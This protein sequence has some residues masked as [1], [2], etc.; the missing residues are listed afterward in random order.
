MMKFAIK[1]IIIF[2]GCLLFDNAD[3]LGQSDRKLVDSYSAVITEDD[4][5]QWIYTA[6]KYKKKRKEYT[7][8]Y[9]VSLMNNVELDYYLKEGYGKNCELRKTPPV[10]VVNLGW[11]IYVRCTV[12]LC[13]TAD[14]CLFTS[15]GEYLEGAWR[16]SL[17]ELTRKSNPLILEYANW[18]GILRLI[19]VS[20][21]KI[22]INKEEDC[23]SPSIFKEFTYNNEGF[24]MGYDG[25]KYTI[26][27]S[28]GHLIVEK[29][30]SPSIIKTKYDNR[31]M[32][33]C[34]I[35][36]GNYEWKKTVFDNAGRKIIPNCEEVTEIEG[37]KG[38]SL[39][40]VRI[41]EY[42]S[43][44]YGIYDLSGNIIIPCEYKEITSIKDNIGDNLFI[45]KKGKYSSDTYYGIYNSL[46]KVLIPCE[47]SNISSIEACN[48]KN[49]F[50][51]WTRATSGQNGIVDVSGNFVIPCEYKSISV[52]DGV[53][54]EKLFKVRKGT[55]PDECGIF[56]CDGNEILAPEFQDCNSLDGN[57]FSFKMNGYWGV[58]NRQGKIII[59]LS[60]QYTQIDYSRT[61]KTF[62]FVKEGGYKGECN[63]SGTQTSIAKVQQPKPQQQAQQ[64]KQE[65]KPQ[66][67]KQE[68]VTPTPT[69]TSSSSSS[70]SSTTNGSG[71]SKLLYQGIYTE[72]NTV[73]D[74]GQSFP[75]VL[76]P[77]EVRIY[78][79]H[80]EDLT[81]DHEFW[82]IQNGRRVYFNSGE[83]YTYYVD[84]NYNITV[85]FN[86]PFG[87]GHATIEYSKGE[88]TMPQGGNYGGSIGTNNG[89]TTVSGSGG[90]K[91]GT[92]GNPAQPHQ[93]TESCPICHG[94]GKCNTCNGRHWYYGYSGNQITCPNCKPDGACTH[95]GGSGKVTK[96]KYY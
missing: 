45:V 21:G 55:Y 41:G 44:T 32:L 60:R 29:A 92:S 40:K 2:L 64:P 16:W 69:S 56:N 62:T 82:K 7:C 28:D 83:A 75:P 81:S 49:Y 78:E 6:K 73:Y 23:K 26:Y 25:Y 22:I 71:N 33:V 13:R 76:G 79:D 10:K 1:C 88:S 20:D 9:S 67:P 51:V 57:Y 48:G 58:M 89:G 35:S 12:P 95:C 70:T 54:G 94:S 93:I 80:L 84:G 66:Q 31:T 47:Y 30:R 3:V 42:S 77:R 19:V 50:S 85:S 90:N 18:C 43:D 74:N 34:E 53:Q 37:R 63:A 24:Y 52:I 8:F 65:T 4:G 5:F 59:P 61:L 17:S 72:G 87:G 36:I 91:S 46:G 15:S 14:D 11:A 39:L 96:T 38:E 68:T 27:S 86:N